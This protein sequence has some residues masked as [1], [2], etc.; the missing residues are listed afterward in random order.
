VVNSLAWYTILA[1]GLFAQAPGKMEGWSKVNSRDGGFSVLFPSPVSSKSQDLDTPA[2]KVH[3]EIYFCRREGAL[4]T[5]QWLRLESAIPPDQAA[6]WLAKQQKAYLVAGTKA[7]TERPLDSN[8]IPGQEFDYDGKSPR[9][10]EPISSRTQHFL[11]GRNYYTLTVM[12]A[13]SRPLP[14]EASSFFDSLKFSGSGDQAARQPGAPAG[15]AGRPAAEPMKLADATPEDALRTFTVAVLAHDEATLKEITLPV[16]GF[17]WLLAGQAA[18]AGALAGLKEQLAK[19]PIRR[20]KAGERFSLPRG[21]SGVVGADEVGA[22]RAVLLPE[23]APLP[24]RLQKVKGHWKVDAR[25]VIAGRQAADAARRKA[26]SKKA[27]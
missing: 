8:G 1:L 17:E 24:S 2:G 7:R 14:R 19:Q 22:D 12:S 18:P 21:K 25:P 26:A 20:L 3:Q 27:G 4:F 16:E 23:G 15:K 11:A 10:T 5:V 13:P 9:T 6:G